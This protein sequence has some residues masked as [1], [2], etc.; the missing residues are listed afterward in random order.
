MRKLSPVVI[1]AVAGLLVSCGGGGGGGDS[2]TVTQTI[3]YSLS[4]YVIDPPFTSGKVYI[5]IEGVQ[6]TY[7]ATITNGEFSFSTQSDTDMTGKKVS[8]CAEGTDGSN[9]YTA[10]NPLCVSLSID[11]TNISGVLISPFHD[12]I[13][14][15][16]SLTKPVVINALSQNYN[17]TYKL[18]GFTSLTEA[19]NYVSSIVQTI[20]S[21]TGQNLGRNMNTVEWEIASHLFI[22]ALKGSPL[23][24]LPMVVSND[25]A[26]NT[27]NTSTMT[28]TCTF[29][30]S[31][32]PQNPFTDNCTV[33]TL[34]MFDIAVPES[35][36]DKTE[37]W[38]KPP[39]STVFFPVAY[40]TIDASTYP[41]YN[42]SDVRFWIMNKIFGLPCDG[43]DGQAGSG[44]EVYLNN[45]KAVSCTFG[46]DSNGGWD[47][48]LTCDFQATV[49]VGFYTTNN[50]LPTCQQTYTS[51]Q[52]VYGR[53][54][55]TRV[56]FSL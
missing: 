31:V 1:G 55:F 19:E 27:P 34:G 33:V 30:N 44:D 13:E 17:I 12:Y 50:P 46:T 10:N 6:G 41:T 26:I 37:V 29:Y 39:S 4:G 52:T 21:Y 56:P 28:Q 54:T 11:A 14:R 40:G 23:S 36:T 49:G 9:T 3:T 51:G 18:K 47:G 20:E 5:S 7:Q 8:L 15:L 32:D 43:G 53:A 35:I 16:D 38:I 24:T 2:Q 25:Q 42:V 45:V 48:T 22:S